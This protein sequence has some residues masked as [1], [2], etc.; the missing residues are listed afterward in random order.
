M[1]MAIVV[2]CHM[3]NAAACIQ[4][5]DDRGPYKTEAECEERI[6]EM[7]VAAVRIHM[8]QGSPFLP[9]SFECRHEGSSI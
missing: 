1:F 3:A 6:E 4:L 2:A 7:L 5:T 8:E 9:K